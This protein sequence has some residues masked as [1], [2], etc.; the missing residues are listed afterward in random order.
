MAIN[1]YIHIPFCRKKCPYCDFYSEVYKHNSAAAYIDIVSKTVQKINAEVS[2]VYIGGGTPTVLG[3]DLWEKML[4][5]LRPVLKTSRET[6]VECNPESLKKEM[7]SLFYKSGITRL[8]IGVQSLDERKLKSL[9]RIHT[10]MKALCAIRE[11]K[12]TGFRNI[13]I[14]LI[15]GVPGESLANWK[16][17]LKE[18][19][20][21]PVTHIS[22]YSLSC[23][24]RTPFYRFRRKLSDT[25][26]A[27]MYSWTI[28][29]LPKHNFSHYEVSNFA[30]KGYTCLHNSF[31]WQGEPYLGI[32]P[33]AVSFINGKRSKNIAHTDEYIRCVAENKSPVV[34]QERLSLLARAREWC[35]VKI[36][37]QRGIYAP[38]CFRY[39]GFEPLDIIS[40]P[41]LTQLKT[42]GLIKIS[43][44]RK[45]PWRIYL[46]KKGFLFA[47]EVSSCFV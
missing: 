25:Q 26:T 10:V 11:A 13:S 38:Q 8:S 41:A 21:L 2:T 31:C 3:L 15:Y 9:G 6:T 33:S 43:Y 44:Q 1:L 35:A 39:T 16:K 37:T 45:R 4:T 29:F 46:T 47:D 42:Q 27:R 28:D 36:R 22:C 34:S 14:D 23:E 40:H 18:A 5:A 30:R 12:Q 32:G 17:E 19:V 24:P 7:L 20:S